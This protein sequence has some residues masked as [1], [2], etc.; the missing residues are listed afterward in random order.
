MHGCILTV[1]LNETGCLRLSTDKRDGSCS[2]CQKNLNVYNYNIVYIYDDIFDS[3]AALVRSFDALIWMAL[4]VDSV[5]P[6]SLAS[7]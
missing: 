2:T 3:P 7:H 4:V 6:I 5:P 1:L